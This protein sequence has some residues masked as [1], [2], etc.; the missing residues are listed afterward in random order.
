MPRINDFKPDTKRL[1]AQRAGYKCCYL[2]CGISTIGPSKENAN[3]NISNTGTAAHIY[4]ASLGKSAR[5]VP[6]PEMTHE[7]I[8]NYTNGIWMCETH[9][10][11]IDTDEITFSVE[12]LRK[13]KYIGE[14]TA[15]RMQE[16]RYS[17][18][19]V[20]TQLESVDKEISE[21]LIYA[22]EHD[23][24]TN[25]YN[26]MDLLLYKRILEMLPDSIIFFARQGLFIN[27]HSS[28]LRDQI[29]RYLHTIENHPVEFTFHNKEIQAKK[30][31][32]DLKLFA[33]ANCLAT[34]TFLEEYKDGYYYAMEQTWKLSE[35]KT[36]YYN[37]AVEE[38]YKCSEDFVNAF[39]NFHK[40][41][42]DYFLE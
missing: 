35:E 30:K 26:T 42:R 39:D 2:G 10:K 14:E 16:F 33:L 9:G 32:M 11:Y 4:S 25:R 18:I 37:N 23:P 34:Y 1:L 41:C 22:Q 24:S 31:K 8:I 12:Q 19:Q 6:P 15:R 40:I 3:L 29:G 17:Y 5:R 38:I 27:R 7:E 13:W 36:K 20:L 28:E 21:M